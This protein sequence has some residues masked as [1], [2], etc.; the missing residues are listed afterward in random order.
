MAVF[1]MVILLLTRSSLENLNTERSPLAGE[2]VKRDQVRVPQ[3]Q[4]RRSSR[5]VLFRLA[6]GIH[7]IHIRKY[8]VE[9]FG[10]LAEL[11]LGE[12][13]VDLLA[14]SGELEELLLVAAVLVVRA[15]AVLA[16]LA[17]PWPCWPRSQPS[18]HR[19]KAGTRP[20]RPPGAP[21]G[22]RRSPGQ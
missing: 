7:K 3:L 22:P 15:A 2:V 16:L 12:G 1:V 4:S 5:K 19:H 18:P 21:P 17:S 6:H 13:L 9:Y 10:R 11:L 14:G 20:G 8:L